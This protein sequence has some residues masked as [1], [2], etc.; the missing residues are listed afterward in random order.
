[1]VKYTTAQKITQ[2][3]HFR[4]TIYL[5]SYTKT[6]RQ[7]RTKRHGCFATLNK[8][9]YQQEITYRLELFSRCAQQGHIIKSKK[10][11][12]RNISFMSFAQDCKYIMLGRKYMLNMK[13][14]INGVNNSL[15]DT[16]YISPNVMVICAGIKHRRKYKINVY[17][18]H[19]SASSQNL[20]TPCVH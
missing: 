7:L 19:Q 1:M 18:K 14:I 9:K 13:L 8:D 5:H 20:I 11:C 10:V 4:N 6:V 12:G 3:V 16:K 2:V 17:R 15:S